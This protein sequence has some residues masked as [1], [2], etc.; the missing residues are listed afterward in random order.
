MSMDR[1]LLSVCILVA[2]TGLLSGLGT[3]AGEG[4]KNKSMKMDEPMSGE[5]KRPGMRKGDVKKHEEKW[6]RKMRNT[7]ENEEKTMRKQEGKP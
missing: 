4:D 1:H 2:A 6:D 5:M 3:L 7:I